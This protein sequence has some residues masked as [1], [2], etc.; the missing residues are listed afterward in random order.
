MKVN[1]IRCVE[2]ATTAPDAETGVGKEAQKKRVRRGR[3]R[4]TRVLIYRVS[5]GAAAVA[6]VGGID[7]AML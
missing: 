7:D 1:K 5:H 6:V 4:R 2:G 3:R